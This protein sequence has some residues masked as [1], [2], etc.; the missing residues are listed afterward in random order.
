[1]LERERERVCFSSQYIMSGFEYAF[2]YMCTSLGGSRR[3]YYFRIFTFLLRF[4][5]FILWRKGFGRPSPSSV[6]P[7]ILVYSLNDRYELL[8]IYCEEKKRVGSCI[9][10]GIELT[11]WSSEGLRGYQPWVLWIFHLSIAGPIQEPNLVFSIGVGVF[12]PGGR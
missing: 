11:T 10:P 12:G 6:I 7:S 5:F 9:P 2:R 4:L 1:M 3:R 8:G